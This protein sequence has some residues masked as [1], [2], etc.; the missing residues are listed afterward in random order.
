MSFFCYCLSCFVLF[1]MAREGEIL[2]FKMVKQKLPL[3]IE[4]VSFHSCGSRLFCVPTC[5][6][7][8]FL[9]PP[10]TITSGL[11]GCGHLCSVI[12]FEK[13]TCLL[14]GFFLYSCVSTLGFLNSFACF[15][16]LCNNQYCP[17]SS[18]I[19]CT[20]VIHMHMLM[21][22]YNTTKRYRQI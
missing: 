12:I 16:V 21:F 19:C 13:C 14:S 2:C 1:C 17:K 10:N 9:L 4:V 15:S 3:L 6:C 5:H 18:Y 20:Y 7:P 11:P 22:M 8:Y